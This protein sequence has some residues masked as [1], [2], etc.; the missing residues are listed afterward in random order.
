MAAFMDRNEN[1]IEPLKQVAAEQRI[2]EQQ[3]GE[4]QPAIKRGARN[5]FPVFLERIEKRK[6]F[7]KR[8]RNFHEELILPTPDDLLPNPYALRPTSCAGASHAS[9]PRP[10]AMPS[11][12][13]STTSRPPFTQSPPA[14]YFGL[15]VRCRASVAT[16]PFLRTSIPATAR[17]KS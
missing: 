15:P 11:A 6:P 17:K 12:T 7:A 2:P 10:A 4:A 8:C 16:V 3:N 5:R 14:K 13:A 9:I 1:K